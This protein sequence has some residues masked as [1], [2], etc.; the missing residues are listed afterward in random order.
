MQSMRLSRR[1]PGGLPCNT[2]SFVCTSCVDST[3]S[4]S[5]MP[6]AVGTLETV[7][8]QLPVGV[9]LLMTCQ[10][11]GSRP[12]EAT[13]RRWDWNANSG[14]TGGIVLSDWVTIDFEKTD[15]LR[16]YGLMPL[17]ATLGAGDAALLCLLRCSPWLARH[18]LS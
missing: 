2:T 15:Y 7:V 1:W 12:P 10:L 8:H 5:I 6:G 18:A 16:T 9:S 14:D 11:T 17:Y 13:R 4:A 3:T